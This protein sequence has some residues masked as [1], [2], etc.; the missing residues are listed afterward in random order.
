MIRAVS[1]YVLVLM[2]VAA[3]F[4][5]AHARGSS[6]DLGK[7]MDMVICTGVGMVTVLVGPDGEPIESVHLC[8][9]GAQVFAAAFAVPVVHSPEARIVARITPLRSASYQGRATLTPSARGPPAQ[10]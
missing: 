9:D 2:L 7:A 1:A 8:P 5:L 6:P 4:T 3:S 10:V